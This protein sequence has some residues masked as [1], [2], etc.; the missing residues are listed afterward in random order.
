MVVCRNSWS[1]G[2]RLA[3]QKLCKKFCEQRK[4]SAPI[5]S[6]K[7]LLN[8]VNLIVYC[9]AIVRV[10]ILHKR[11]NELREKHRIPQLNSTIRVQQNA[12]S[13]TSKPVIP[14]RNKNP[15]NEIV[16]NL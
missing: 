6:A 5:S 9:K 4:A 13:K 14:N 10:H 16:F 8:I 15:P 3:K 7:K 2:S 12:L 11:P 1:R